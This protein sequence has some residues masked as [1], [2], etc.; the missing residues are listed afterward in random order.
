MS[1]TQPLH[2]LLARRWSPRDF[3]PRPI[4]PDVLR[5][6]FEA[7]RWSASCFNEQPWRFVIA[8][9]DEPEDFARVLDCLVPKNQEWAR[10]AFVLG[11]TSGTKTFAHNGTPNR[12]GLH[13]TGAALANLA[14]QASAHGIFVHPMG[15]FVHEKAR[16]NLS[17]PEDYDLGAAFAIG[18]IP[19]S[20][21]RPRPAPATPLPSWSSAPAGYHQV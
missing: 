5:S 6:L 8:T 14:I 4:P 13:D 16:T 2:D 3:S 7:A 15:G 19:G 10:N 17:I 18:Y 1:D 11:I 9:Q 12:Y 20:P 21:S